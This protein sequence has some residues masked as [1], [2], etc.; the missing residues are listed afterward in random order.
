MISSHQYHGQKQSL[1]QRISPQQIQYI[2]LLQLPTASLEQRIEE[3]LENNPLLEETNIEEAGDE[4]YLAHHD[5]RDNEKTDPVDRSENAEWETLEPKEEWDTFTANSLSEGY[6]PPGYTSDRPGRDIPRPYRSTLLENL[7]EQVNL[8][9]LDENQKLIADQIIGSIEDDGYMRRDLDAIIDSVAFHSGIVV[10]RDDAEQVLKTIQRL[11]PAGIAARD[12]KECLL[13]QLEVMG[14]NSDGINLAFRI[15][16]DHWELF[17]KKHYEKLR[18]K[19]SANKEDLKHAFHR[20]KLLDPKPG[21]LVEDTETGSG[22]ENYI[23]PDFN[24]KYQPK[25]EKAEKGI[26][27]DDGDFIISLNE[28]NAPK[29]RISPRYVELWNSIITGKKAPEASDEQTR[30]FIKNKI[31]SARWFI[32]GI[33]QRQHTL[34][35][36][37]RTIVSLQKD[38]FAYG[39]ELRPMI[40]KDVANRINMD[41]STVSRVSNGKFVQ[42][43]FGV[44][45][46]KYF[47]NEAIKTRDGRE[48]SS[49][50]VKKL[51]ENIIGN[52]DKSKPL[53]DEALTAELEKK[54]YHI[55][56]RTVSK[57]REQLNIPVARL[58][59]GF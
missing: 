46:L 28:K 42:T 27:G 18:K 48:V 33:V 24:V 3:E 17:E 51:L 40:L 9:D 39:G 53:S 10:Q 37:M 1:Q 20:I 52:E 58:R 25:T 31:E 50:A 55:A 34:L 47:F 4:D 56:R 21:N 7:E 36:V 49:R 22:T 16:K 35:S 23:I 14:K 19:I 11:E 2:K 30:E 54:G 38:F 5:D 15:V 13:V 44:Y 29:L 8:L 57:Y 41:I 45:P 6:I 32:D 43:P 12:L 59:V 26:T